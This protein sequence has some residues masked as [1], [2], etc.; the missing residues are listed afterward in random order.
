MYRPLSVVIPSMKTLYLPFL[1]PTLAL[2]FAT[3]STPP[4]VITPR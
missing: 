2:C 4:L 1:A 3:T